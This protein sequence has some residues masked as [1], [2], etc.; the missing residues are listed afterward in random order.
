MAT[1][2]ILDNLNNKVSDIRPVD[3]PRVAIDNFEI[4]FR[5]ESILP[6]RVQ[7]RP[8]QIEPLG[9]GNTPAIPLQIIGYSNYIL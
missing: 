4:G 9:L 3:Y 7:F 8:I 1:A 6:F 5:A 2:I